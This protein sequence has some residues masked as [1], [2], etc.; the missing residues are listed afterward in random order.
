MLALRSFKRRAGEG[1]CGVG[2][3]LEERL[4]RY[5]ET[6][7]QGTSAIAAAAVSLACPAD[8][9]THVPST[10]Y[11]TAD[12]AAAGVANADTVHC[13][14]TDDAEVVVIYTV[15]IHTCAADIAICIATTAADV[16]VAVAVVVVF[17]I[18]TIVLSHE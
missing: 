10:V 15:V 17:V 14:V 6:W 7:V 3:A 18:V 1:P 4:L 8:T 5:L 16:A 2:G 11:A 13:V 12:A 9:H